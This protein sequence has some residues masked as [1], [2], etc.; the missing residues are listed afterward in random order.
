MCTSIIRFLGVLAM[1]RT[2]RGDELMGD[3]S[4]DFKQLTWEAGEEAVERTKE[5]AKTAVGTAKRSADEHGLTGDKLAEKVKHV[6]NDAAKSAEGTSAEE[7]LTPAEIKRDAK[8]VAQDTK[9]AATKQ[10]N[11]SQ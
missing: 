1:P 3:A 11:K 9:T 8:E 10:A 4:D 2:R 5:V 7:G 6:V